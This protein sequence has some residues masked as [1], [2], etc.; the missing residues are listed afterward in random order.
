MMQSLH[1]L[2]EENSRLRLALARYRA[3]QQFS[4]AR[5]SEAFLRDKLRSKDYE[6]ADT[7]HTIL[8]LLE[9]IKQTIPNHVLPDEK[10]ECCE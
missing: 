4:E 3:S 1:D 9:E 2:A 8:A 6:F 7:F 10:G 5:F